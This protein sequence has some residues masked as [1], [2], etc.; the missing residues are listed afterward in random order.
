MSP[1][2]LFVIIFGFGAGVIRSL[3]QTEFPNAQACSDARE[4]FPSWATTLTHRSDQYH[5]DAV[6][7][8]KP[9][10]RQVSPKS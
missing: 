8:D 2:I 4:S 7:L 10:G 9:T 3:S 6:C 1:T 5:M